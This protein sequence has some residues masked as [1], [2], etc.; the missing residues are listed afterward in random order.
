MLHHRGSITYVVFQMKR[1]YLKFSH[2]LFSLWG[3]QGSWI[4]HKTMSHQ[5]SLEINQRIFK[6]KDK[7]TFN[8][9]TTRQ[10]V[11]RG[12]EDMVSLLGDTPGI[13]PISIIFK[14]KFGDTPSVLPST[15][16]PFPPLILKSLNAW[17]WGLKKGFAHCQ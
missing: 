12:L 9:C 2:T 7:S 8:S 3:L 17:D 10:A 15:Q 11:F 5:N 6:R 16:L 14:T 13:L 1:I 4:Q